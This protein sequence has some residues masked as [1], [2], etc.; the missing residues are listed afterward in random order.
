MSEWL[1]KSFQEHSIIWLLISSILGGL[2][3]ATF[4][5]LFE[6]LLPQRLTQRREFLYDELCF[7]CSAIKKVYQYGSE[8]L[9]ERPGP[10][11]HR[12]KENGY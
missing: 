7:L 1:T 3:G 5:F 6:T 2:F 9:A 8:A 12:L 4:E 10:F 11:I